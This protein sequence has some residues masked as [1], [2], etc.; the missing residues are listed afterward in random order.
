MPPS[1]GSKCLILEA[2]K[3]GTIFVFPLAYQGKPCHIRSMKNTNTT[4]RDLLEATIDAV[5]GSYPSVN[6]ILN[7]FEIMF[8][9][10]RKADLEDA[11]AAK[12]AAYAMLDSMTDRKVYHAKRYANRSWATYLDSGFGPRINGYEVGLR[13]EVTEQEH[14]DRALGTTGA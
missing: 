1:A 4:Y 5:E 7:G 10:A 11:K 8:H 2:K 12:D 9:V 6:V 14:N 13:I 3:S